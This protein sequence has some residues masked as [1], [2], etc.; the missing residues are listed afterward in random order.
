VT[1]R[2]EAAAAWSELDEDV[3]D[4][5]D[6]DELE[7]ADDAEVDAVAPLLPDVVVTLVPVD[8]L[9]GDDSPARLSSRPPVSTMAPAT[10]AT[11]A[12]RRP[13]WAG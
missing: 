9:L 5:I 2:P 3:P 1:D 6:A 12:M 8:P 13:V 10:L 4:E 7:L 11:A